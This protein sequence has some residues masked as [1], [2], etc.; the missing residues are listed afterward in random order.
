MDCFSF[1]ATAETPV[2]WEKDGET[3]GGGSSGGKTV[4]KRNPVQRI[5]TELRQG[6]RWIRGAVAG[7]KAEPENT[8][9]VDAAGVL[10]VP[11]AAPRNTGNYVCSVN[12]T[13]KGT[14]QVEVIA[15]STLSFDG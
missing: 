11:K 4:H 14:F 3:I 13:P 7:I 8:P 1:S 6:E 9:I 10:K 15:R 12:G 2:Q 5:I